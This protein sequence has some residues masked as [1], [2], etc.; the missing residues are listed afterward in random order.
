MTGTAYKITSAI[1]IIILVVLLMV[2]AAAFINCQMQQPQIIYR[3]SQKPDAYITNL[4]NDPWTKNIVKTYLTIDNRGATGLITVH[5]GAIDPSS[6][7]PPSTYHE[8]QYYVKGGEHKTFEEVWDVPDN[9][10]YMLC[11]LVRQE[12]A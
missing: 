10:N 3:T 2:V 12:A 6:G 1:I 5:Y 9:Q 7:V 8:R 11:Y 4:T